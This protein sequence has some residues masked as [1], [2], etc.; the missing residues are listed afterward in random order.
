MGNWFI[1]TLAVP[2]I[3]DTQAGF[4]MFTAKA[5]SVIFPRQTIDRW[6]YDIEL[7]AIARLHRL[8]VAEIPITWINAEGSKVTLKSYLQVFGDVL[9]IRSNLRAGLYR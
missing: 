6:G 9:K 3:R 5:A 7:L 4:K 1:R 2:G 8:K